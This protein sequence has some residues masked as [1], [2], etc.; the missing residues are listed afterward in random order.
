MTI[1]EYVP[2]VMP[3]GLPHV[4]RPLEEGTTGKVVGMK[5]DRL[6][7]EAC[8]G[9]RVA[10]VPD[11]VLALAEGYDTDAALMDMDAGADVMEVAR[12]RLHSH[13]GS[14]ISGMEPGAPIRTV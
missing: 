3:R 11:R 12:K 4:E 7:V 8:G 14:R 5:G 9:R 1:E 2:I 6:I 13:M 10:C